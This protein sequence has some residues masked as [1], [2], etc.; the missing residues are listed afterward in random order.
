M[1]PE[2]T[3]KIKEELELL[4]TKAIEAINKLELDAEKGMLKNPFALF[5]FIDGQPQ[6]PLTSGVDRVIFKAMADDFINYLEIKE[7]EE[8]IMQIQDEKLRSRLLSNLGK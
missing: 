3:K 5:T 6:F 7:K 1:N 4:K 2:Q 8:K